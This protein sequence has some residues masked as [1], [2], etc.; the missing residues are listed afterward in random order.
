V[1]AGYDAQTA[2]VP[3][4]LIQI[5]H[6]FDLGKIHPVFLATQ[7]VLAVGMPADRAAVADV[8]L[9]ADPE[10]IRAEELGDDGVDAFISDEGCQLRAALDKVAVAALL[11]FNLL[12]VIAPDFFGGVRDC[13]HLCRAESL[14]KE[15]ES[16]GV[17][18]G[19]LLR[20]QHRSR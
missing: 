5:D 6:H 4:N 3:V 12:L 8:A 20:C 14:A 17:E 11:P 15:H 19:R 9:R 18:V 7:V 1:G 10:Q 13:R 2:A 16:E